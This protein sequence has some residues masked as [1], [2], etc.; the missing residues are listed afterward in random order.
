M[1]FFWIFL[2]FPLLTNGQYAVIRGVAPLAIGQEIQLRVYDDPISG[3]ERVLAKQTIDVDGSFELKVIP[4]AEVQYALLQVGQNCADFFIQRDA[5]L[6]LSFVPPKEDPLK[7][8]AFNE[9]QF[10]VPKITGGKSAGLNR[11]IIAFN[12]SIDAF[13]ES[14]YPLLKQR[15]SPG[16]VAEQLAEFEKKTQ[17]DFKEAD[18]FV[19]GYIQYSIAGIEQTFLSDKER[20]YA[21]YLKEKTPQFNNPAFVDFALQF[22]Q[23]QV[24]E[25]AV[26]NKHEECKK[27]L[28]GKEAF[29]KMDEMLLAAEPKLKDVSLRRMVLIEGFDRLFGQKD[30]EDAKLIA[31]LKS[32]G[33]LSSNS[34]LGN[35]AKNV[36]ANHESLAN[37]TMAPE[38]VFTATDGSEKKLSD[39][40]GTYIFLELTDATNGYSNRETNVIPNLKEEFEFI[41]FVT[42]CVGN[43]E[44]EVLEL[45]KKMNIDWELGRIALSSVALEDYRIKSLPLFFIIDPS[46]K[47]YA[48]PAKDP[49]KGAQGQLMSLNEKLKAKGKKSVGK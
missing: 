16:F 39:L 36:A 34:Y 26:V 35:A 12:D 40:Q 33:G 44:Q 2:V 13:L 27:L 38:L 9:R 42:I 29:A 22:Y 8:K 43:S 24:Y 45:K 20:L 17:K 37:G 7:P 41:R 30:F 19:Q 6:E 10:F 15:K 46:G 3:K 32:F 14:I 21:K 11:H 49:T 47:F 18:S 48:A 25:L 5:D 4:N 28:D 1:R 31:A 23:G